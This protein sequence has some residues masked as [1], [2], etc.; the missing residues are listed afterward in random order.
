LDGCKLHRWSVRVAKS[1][2]AALEYLHSHGIAHGD[3]Y[4]HNML[5]AKDG[6]TVLCDYGAS[7]FYS[8]AQRPLWEAV[9]VP[10][11]KHFLYGLWSTWLRTFFG[12]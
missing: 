7:F 10:P 12:I 8:A 1:T 9:E 2:A 11:L 3:V 5:A 6:T 4:A